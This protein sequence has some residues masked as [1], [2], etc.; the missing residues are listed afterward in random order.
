[1]AKVNRFLVVVAL[2]LAVASMAFSILLAQRRDAFRKRSEMLAAT[3]QEM[4]KALDDGSGT[5]IA[6]AVSFTAADPALGTKEEG[7][8]GWKEYVASADG[9]TAALA[10][11]K[12]LAQKV[13][14]QRNQLAE[15]LAAV[16]GSLGQSVPAADLANL[17]K[18][19]EAAPQVANLA[20]ATK[21]RDEL[22]AQTLLGVGT[23]TGQAVDREALTSYDGKAFSQAEAALKEVEAGV[24]Q[25]SERHNEY[26]KTLVETVEALSR[27]E[28]DVENTA[29]LR[30]PVAY[31]AGTTAV[32]NG[33]R[34]I[35]LKLE[36]RE[37]VKAQLEERIKELE[38]AKEDRAKAAVERDESKAKLQ[39]VTAEITE[40]KKILEGYTGKPGGV[41]GPATTLDPNLVGKVMYVDKDFKY[42]VL[43]LGKGQIPEKARLLVHRGNKYLGSVQVSRVADSVAIAE[44]LPSSKK[45]K[46]GDSVIP[47]LAE[48]AAPVAGGAK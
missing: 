43:N 28:W 1:M 18:S 12:E 30:D 36:E 22:M 38:L 14:A 44:I 4:A 42:V 19:A 48:A 40:L 37:R 45:I 32:L 41:A 35:N 5:E 47:P 10:K 26:A 16:A 9:Y 6:K 24:G 29:K 3:V 46:D 34:D 13:K 17:A 15:Q 21:T 11:A 20:A 27:H 7:K 33:A 2:L 8:L 25:L 31:R 39:A 23:T